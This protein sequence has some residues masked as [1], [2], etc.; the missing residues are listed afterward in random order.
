MTN[1]KSPTLPGERDGFIDSLRGVAVFGILLSNILIFSG[2]LFTPFIRLEQYGLPELNGFLYTLSQIFISGKFYPIFCILFGYGFY[3]QVQKFSRADSP[4]LSYFSKRLF[5]LLIIGLL[6]QLIWPGDVVTTYALI[7]FMFLAVRNSSQKQDL[8]LAIVF[9]L[10][11]FFIGLIPFLFPPATAVVQSAVQPISY[12]SFPGVENAE[13]IQQVRHGGISGM[14]YFYKPQYTFLWSTTRLIRT[15]PSVIALFF[16]GGFLFKSGYIKNHIHKTRHLVSLLLIGAIG[17]I[18]YLNV[19]YGFRLI[20]NLF[21]SLFY[22]GFLAR[23][24]RMGIGKWI[25][26]RFIPVGRMALTSYILQSVFCIMIFYGIGGIGLFAR[27]ALYQVYLIAAVILLIQ[28]VFCNLW[29]NRFRFGP[30]EWIWRCLSY[31]KWITLRIGKGNQPSV[32]G[33][34][35]IK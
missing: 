18:L 14:Y 10:V 7:G 28:I 12:F 5:Y 9:F 16:L 32:D 34:R 25:L 31:Q 26:N 24:Q 6:H 21:L 17:T 23:L 33:I 1:H 22:I 27:L 11:S 15:T 8:L 4:F 30:V 3:M 20:D 13:L 29:L 19:A 2:F 35:P